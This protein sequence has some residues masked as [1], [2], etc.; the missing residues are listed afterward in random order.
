MDLLDYS[1]G[2]NGPPYDQDDWLNLF[3]A[4]FQYNS[5]LVEEIF[6]EPPG[7]DKIVY[8]ETEM[9]V[10]GYVC[11]EDLTEQFIEDIGDWSP[12]D[13]IDANWLVFKL[14][15]KDKYPNYK[16]IKILVQ[17]D[18]PYAGW[19]LFAEGELDSEGDIQFYSMQD[20]VDDIMSELSQ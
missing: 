19:A 14:E 8:G 6:F 16:E 18:V 10:T 1:D 3:V 4:S 5:E 15:D 13:P 2:S 17:P 12:V 20:I 11:D 9:E 7:F